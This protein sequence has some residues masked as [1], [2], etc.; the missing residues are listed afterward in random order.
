MKDEKRYQWSS[1]GG[2]EEIK[3]KKSLVG[4]EGILKLFILNFI[5]VTST[6]RTHELCKV[7]SSSVDLNE[8]WSAVF[9]FILCGKK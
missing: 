1:T 7:S 2:K 4:Q 5:Y 9:S 3:L 8:L 6:F